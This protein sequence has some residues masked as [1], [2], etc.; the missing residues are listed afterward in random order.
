M[1][2]RMG[3]SICIHNSSYTQSGTMKCI[4]LKWNEM[5]KIKN[6]KEGVHDIQMDFEYLI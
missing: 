6:R 4:S 5:K 2:C 1:R 3:V